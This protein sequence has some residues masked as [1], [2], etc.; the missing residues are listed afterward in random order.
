MV[1]V[2]P[3]ARVE[4]GGRNEE[5]KGRVDRAASAA[6]WSLAEALGP[7]WGSFTAV[8]TAKAWSLSWPGVKGWFPWV[9]KLL[10]ALSRCTHAS[11]LLQGFHSSQRWQGGAGLMGSGSAVLMAKFH[12]TLCT[13]LVAAVLGPGWQRARPWWS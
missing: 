4:G 10:P 12:D 5:G 11:L 3:M 13:G 8:R 9:S 2:Q 7:V 1:C 6:A